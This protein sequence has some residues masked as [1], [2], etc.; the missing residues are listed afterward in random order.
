MA[1]AIEY[2]R[3]ISDMGMNAAQLASAAVRLSKAALSLLD[4]QQHTA[5]HPRLGVVD[6]I[7]CNPLGAQA[8]LSSA[9]EA[10]QRIGRPIPLTLSAVCKV[11]GMTQKVRQRC[12]NVGCFQ[13]CRTSCA[14]WANST[15]TGLAV[16]FCDSS[17][18]GQSLGQGEDAVPVLLYGA[19]HPAGQTLASIRRASGYF[20]GSGTGEC[21]SFLDVSIWQHRYRLASDCQLH[22]RGAHMSAMEAVTLR[23]T[24]IALGACRPVRR[25]QLH[26][27]AREP[28]AGLWTCLA[29]S[30]AW[31]C[32]SGCSALGGEL[33]RA[34]AHP[35]HAGLSE[36][37]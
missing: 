36:H 25:C 16:R 2:G 27:A 26:Q 35:G 8:D 33:Q 37:C 30:Q 14:G 34:S 10:A 23:R 6:H 1:H 18:T 29:R 9:A 20:K 21:C 32:F 7:V 19:A 28:S 11:L 31:L 3:L 4:L 15:H 24:H 12:R 13:S 5:T 17:M 22:A